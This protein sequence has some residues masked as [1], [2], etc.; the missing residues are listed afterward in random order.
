MATG[1][2]A[3]AAQ[4][5]AGHSTQGKDAPGAGEGREGKEE[6]PNGLQCAWR[7]VARTSAGLSCPVAKQSK[8]KQK[9]DRRQRQRPL[10]KHSS[11]SG[12]HRQQRHRGEEGQGSATIAPRVSP[13]Q[14][15]GPAPLSTAP[16]APRLPVRT[17]RFGFRLHSPQCGTLY[18]AAHPVSVLL[19]TCFSP[20]CSRT[21]ASVPLEFVSAAEPFLSPLRPQRA[22]PATSL[23]ALVIVA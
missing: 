3:A 16:A 13:P 2:V 9:G 8:G 19:P 1:R 17:D 5:G 15:G 6:A 12:R 20:H 10:S 22:A 21:F 4:Q 14:A 7:S 11:T 18:C 23:R